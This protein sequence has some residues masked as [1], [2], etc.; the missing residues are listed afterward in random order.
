MTSDP[1]VRIEHRIDALSAPTAHY[2]EAVSYGGLYYI[3]GML[4]V[5]EG[6]KLFGGDDVTAQ[7]E[8]VFRNIGAA[9]D[10]VGCTFADVLK[11]RIFVTSIGDRAKIDAVRRSVFGHTKPV[12]TLV[13]I[14]ALAVPG[15]KIE[16][17]ATAALPK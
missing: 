12:S 8:Q 17:E 9:L 13:E 15:A 6:G 11:M 1:A 14:G 16:V 4:P 2:S 10:H 7:A 3:A 5:D